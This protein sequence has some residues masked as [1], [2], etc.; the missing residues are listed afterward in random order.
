MHVE[1]KDIFVFLKF[2]LIA[3]VIVQCLNMAWRITTNNNEI[4]AWVRNNGGRPAVVIGTSNENTAGM[5]RID[6][7]Q[8]PNLRAI[9]YEEFFDMF[10]RNNL[11]LRYTDEPKE[12][13][14]ND[15][16]PEDKFKFVSR[17][18]IPPQPEDNRTELP[19]VGDA[20][21]ARENLYSSEEADGHIRP[22]EEPEEGEEK[23]Q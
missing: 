17:E 16:N 10:E 15:V 7:N 4:Q 2:V 1:D 22:R 12:D 9:S 19:D 13:I 20:E 5:L 3:K 6:F 23:L 8:D 21:V 18:N 11:A 14:G